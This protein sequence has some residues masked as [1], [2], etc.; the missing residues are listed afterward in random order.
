VLVESKNNEPQSKKRKVTAFRLFVG[1]E[2]Q[3]PNESEQQG[4]PKRKEGNGRG[5]D[6]VRVACADAC[7]ERSLGLRQVKLAASSAQS[8]M[9]ESVAAAP[10]LLREVGSM[11]RVDRAPIP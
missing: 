10:L 7:G 6:G 9:I 2:S 11:K 3:R 4:T 8:R 1:D 5:G